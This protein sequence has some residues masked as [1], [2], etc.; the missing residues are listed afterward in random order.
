[1]TPSQIREGPGSQE[2][3]GGCRE[4]YD[5]G[6]V[7]IAAERGDNI[8][9]TSIVNRQR[10]RCELPEEMSVIRRSEKYYG[11]EL[12]LHDEVEGENRNYLLT[13]PG[14]N[15]DLQL[16]V[17]K[18]SKEGVRRS[19]EKAAIV[20]ASLAAEQPPYELCEQCGEPIRSIEHDRKAVTGHCSRAETWK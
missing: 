10:E 6:T 9:L 19:W 17:G 2:V 1:M 8:V 18:L 20:K 3:Q 11:P 16:W 15:S 13:A 14:P 5:S 12:L 4:E 7:M